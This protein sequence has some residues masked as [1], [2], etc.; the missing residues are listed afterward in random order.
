MRITRVMLKKV[1]NKPHGNLIM[2]QYKLALH[3]GLNTFE[4]KQH[5]KQ[6]L[7]L[8]GLKTTRDI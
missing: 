6:F 1:E 7:V 5:L 3:K 8:S 2:Q 4:G